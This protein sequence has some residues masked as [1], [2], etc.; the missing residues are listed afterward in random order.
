MAILGR[1]LLGDQGDLV[2]Y[3][4]VMCGG[5]ISSSFTGEGAKFQEDQLVGTGL[6]Q[7]LNPGVSDCGLCFLRN[8]KLFSYMMK[9]A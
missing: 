5:V 7:E 2:W 1:T 6:T 3:L 8:A 9:K 4:T